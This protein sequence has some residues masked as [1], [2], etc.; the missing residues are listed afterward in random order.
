MGFFDDFADGFKIPFEWVYHQSEK[1]YDRFDRLA[2]KSAGALGDGLEG[3]G[4]FLK[5]PM[6]MIA[7]VIGAIMLISLMKS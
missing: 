2:D 5:N 1:A 4:N 6:L 3:I 7:L